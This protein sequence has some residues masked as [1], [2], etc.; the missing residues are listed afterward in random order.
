MK[1]HGCFGA[2][3]DFRRAE[4]PYVSN[5]SWKFNDRETEHWVPHFLTDWPGLGEDRDGE[6]S[7]PLGLQMLGRSPEQGR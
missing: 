7:F 1:I 2:S 4:L 5:P 6:W 3:L